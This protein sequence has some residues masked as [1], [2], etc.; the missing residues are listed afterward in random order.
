[1]ERKTQS[2]LFIKVT[3]QRNGIFI[4]LAISIFVIVLQAISLVRQEKTTVIVPNYNGEEFWVSNKRVSRE[5]IELISKEIINS[6][7]NITPQNEK[8]VKQNILKRA[9]PSEYGRMK[10]EIE[11]VQEDLKVRQ[12]SMRYAITHINV[13]EAK[14]EAEISGYL[15]SYVGLKETGKNFTKY[16]IGY[17]YA[18][19]MLMINEFREISKEEMEG[20]VKK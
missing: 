2:E 18:G 20:G 12:I 15:T 16:K 6:I 8:Y 7:L 14:L 3:K 11:K 19:G 5:Y 10:Y 13:S 4:L 9:S 17:E 1:M